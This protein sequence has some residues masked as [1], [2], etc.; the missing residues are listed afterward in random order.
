M[1]V[2]LETLLMQQNSRNGHVA[3][4][5]AMMALVTLPSCCFLCAPRE[6]DVVTSFSLATPAATFHSF[7]EAL[8]AG[9]SY[10]EFKC[11]SDRF[12]KDNDIDE[13]KYAIGR[14]YFLRKYRSE[15]SRFK[16]SSIDRVLFSHDEDGQEIALV[17]LTDGELQ[18]EFVLINEPYWELELRPEDPTEIGPEPPYGFP[19]RLSDH[20]EVVGSELRVRIDIG[21]RPKR[22]AEDIVG[23]EL[24]NEWKVLQFLGMSEAL[25]AEEIEDNDTKNTEPQP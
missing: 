4:F 25:T 16:A 19:E 12:K 15:V 21:R 17:K 10:Y 20:I 5:L 1:S 23:I 14:G 13:Q 11:I 22:R 8:E 18:G 9:S 3:L 6:A 24:K 7:K 2:V